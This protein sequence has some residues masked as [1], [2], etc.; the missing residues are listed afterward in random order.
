MARKKVPTARRQRPE[1]LGDRMASGLF[2]ALR[3][4]QNA[5]IHGAR[6]LP[7]LTGL[8]HRNTTFSEPQENVILRAVS[9]LIASE[10][11]FSYGDSI[12]L[13]IAKL[14]GDG[15]R[16]AYL[17]NGNSVATGSNHWL[18]NVFYCEA[19]EFQFPVPK[20]FCDLL[21]RSELLQ[22]A[23]LRIKVYAQRPL[24]DE[25]FILRG[26][27]WHNDVGI[28][29]HG[30]E[31]EPVP[32]MAA[33]EG[34]PAIERL[35]QHL[36]TLLSGFCFASDADVANAV[37]AML[38]GMLVNH[39]IVDGKA[40]LLVDGNQPG[41]GKTLLVRVIG[42]VCDYIDPPLLHFTAEEEELQ[43]RICA[44]L[45]GS[46]GSV[47]LIDNA[48]TRSGAAVSSAVIEANS[49]A[50]EINLRI[51]GTSE[52]LSRPNDLLW[53]ITMNQTKVSPDIASRSMPI[54]LAYEGRPE[55][56]VFPGPDPIEY[57]RTYRLEILSELAGMVL[58]W[59]QRGRPDGLAQHRLTTWSR[60]IGGILQ[61][62][63]LNEF[64][65]NAADAAAQF[66]VAL[67]DLAAVAEAVVRG[68][69][70]FTTPEES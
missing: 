19:E 47:L 26:P 49:V 10:K 62:A 28:M 24:F 37:G 61:A 58:H 9:Y 5:P 8:H 25:D 23:I 50:P 55:K 67:D 52:N 30:P 6:D 44:T 29:I 32:F 18:S 63:G 14:S 33:S 66:N 15:D 31:I 3:E 64:L 12:V 41:L 53:A 48:K 1:T 70:P 40:I 36:Q 20:W 69:G 46:P 21:L 16:L 51:L 22:A 68:G 65:S 60:I 45:R 59:N 17:R 2:K 11:V 35:P 4:I 57:A 34:A 42:I 54:R 39:F 7:I 56:R 13:A 27:G 38:T 43:K